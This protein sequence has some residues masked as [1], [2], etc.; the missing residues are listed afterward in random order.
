[1]GRLAQRVSYSQAAST[2]T[3]N[4]LNGTNLQY[5]GRAANMTVWA[6]CYLAAAHDSAAL[7]Y[8]LGTEFTTFVPPGTSLNNNASG[9]QQLNDLWGTFAVPAG[10]NLTLA[11]TSDATAGTHTGAFAFLLE[12]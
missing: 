6:S 1:M 10:A 11:V 12:N 9:P 2:T 4:L 5:V 8:S 3:A 7:S